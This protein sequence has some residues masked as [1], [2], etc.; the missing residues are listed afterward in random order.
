MVADS[1]SDSCIAYIALL[2]IDWD[3]CTVHDVGFRV[4]PP[5]CNKGLGTQLLNK[6]LNWCFEGQLKKIRLTVVAPNTPAVRC[7]Q[8]CGF[9]K[10]GEFW[11]KDK[12]LVKAN[13]DEQRYTFLKPHAVLKGQDVLVRCWQMEV[14][15]SG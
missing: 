12:R 4:S 10:V 13:L 3:E 5:L 14:T 7:Y 6:V 15:T 2:G 9:V 8:K 11:K 1:G